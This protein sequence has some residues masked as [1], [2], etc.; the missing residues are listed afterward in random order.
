MRDTSCMK[1]YAP[2]CPSK[3]APRWEDRPGD[4]S[5]ARRQDL[6]IADKDALNEAGGVASLLHHEIVVFLPFVCLIEVSFI[7]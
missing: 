4:Q 3:A 2:L 5:R 7:M 1:L 6:P